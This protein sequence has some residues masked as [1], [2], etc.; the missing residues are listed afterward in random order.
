M[1][2]EHYG[3]CSICGAACGLTVEMD[4]GEILKIRGDDKDPLSKGYI[5]PKGAAL[6]ELHEDP[7]RI[8]AS[9]RRDGDQWRSV[10]WDEALS[11]IARRICAIQHEHGRDA[12]GLYVG[13]PASHS[14]GTLFFLAP[15]LLTLQTKNFFTA[16]SVDALPRLL[17]SALL[18]GSS[19]MLPVPDV[20]RTDYLLMIGAN[21]IVS[22]GSIMTAPGFARNM[23]SIQSRGGRIV[24]ID[25]RRTETAEKADEHLFIRPGT[26]ALLL[27][28]IIHTLF[29]EKL[30][31]PGGL[32]ERVN[33]IEAIR[34]IAVH[35]PPGR[36]APVTGIPADEIRRLAR[37]FAK[38][39]SAVC[40]GR[41]GT[42]TQEFGTMASWL[43]CV[44]NI[45]TGNLDRPGGAMFATPALDMVSILSMLGSKGEF[46]RWKSR[47]R[48][49]PE[50]DREI[51][52]AAMSDEIETPGRGQLKALIVVAG[53]PV[54]SLPNGRR[55]DRALEGLD[56]MVSLDLYRNETSR[57]ADYILP[58][59]V[60][61][62]QDHY[63]L[64]P[65][66]ISVKNV[67]RWV[68]EILHRPSAVRHD[69]EILSDLSERIL[70]NRGG[71]SKITARALSAAG[72]VAK[73]QKL[74]ALALRLGPYGPG[75]NPFGKGL[76]LAE[77][78]KNVHGVD[79]G[80]LEPMLEKRLAKRKVELAP[81]LLMADLERL[82][83]RLSEWESEPKERNSLLLIAHRHI[84]TM[85]SWMHN[86]ESL[87]KG[88]DRCMLHLNPK[89]ARRRGIEEGDAVKV[90][91]RVGEIEIH[92]HITDAM[93]RG[94]VSMPF[95]WGH[96][97]PGTKQSVAARHAGVSIN[98]VN[99][100]SLLDEL[101]GASNFNGVP[102]TVEKV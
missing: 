16:N 25:P 59:S 79:L 19:G 80:P 89:D 91:S 74:L 62:E 82:G 43:I 61:L 4:R 29:A 81:A 31:S 95:G 28:A 54:L 6:K 32:A 23:R 84:R 102:V 55:L 56:L 39:R 90:A 18:Y 72:A 65:Y 70:K 26:D 33:G 76:T 40:Y 35:Y 52:A 66:A 10:S 14:Y 1:S 20:D 42:C 100:D 46:G 77:L 92:A 47:V 101:S 5:C 50:L 86:L 27:L 97:R 99:D 7:D 87:A 64:V 45:V 83:R 68:P 11:D 94:V 63:P 17:A 44:L 3:M 34:R 13:T 57:H 21:P 73:P 12:V 2:T 75:L 60:G 93:M 67:A 22:N 51:P 85:N 37:A 58:P 96:D 9:M 30:E 69:W 38:A 24:V 88:K 8:T 15:F 41:M 98:D 78:K 36:V 49:L 71:A 53:N 48:G